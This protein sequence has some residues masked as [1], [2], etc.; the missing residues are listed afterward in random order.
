[1]NLSL[2]RVLVAPA[3]PSASNR[4]PLCSQQSKR[5]AMV[6]RTL[7]GSRAYGHK[8]ISRPQRIA[9]MVAT[10][11]AIADPRIP[12]RPTARAPRCSA[13]DYPSPGCA[14][15]RDSRRDSSD[16]SSLLKYV[17]SN[18]HS[19]FWLRNFWQTLQRLVLGCIEA[20]F[21]KY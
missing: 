5:G 8:T 19:N 9:S 2:I 4:G 3:T 13:P 20:A 18:F 16:Q 10:P 15:S 12:P 14:A 6:R 7:Q 17:F 21:C 1:M 11:S